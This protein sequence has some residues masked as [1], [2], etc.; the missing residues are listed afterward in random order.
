MKKYSK[1]TSR[2]PWLTNHISIKLEWINPL[3]ESILE[4]Q[5]EEHQRAYGVRGWVG[6]TVTGKM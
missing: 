5:S 2:L 6:V 4:A 3:A 1:F